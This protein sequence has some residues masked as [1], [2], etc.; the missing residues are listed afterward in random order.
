MI[1]FLKKYFDPECGEK[2]NLVRENILSMISEILS[3]KINK[4]KL[5][6]KKKN[7]LMGSV[8]KFNKMIHAEHEKIFS[9]LEKP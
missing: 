2:N 3:N 5:N 6:L 9:H 4:I 7:Y 8:K 1:F